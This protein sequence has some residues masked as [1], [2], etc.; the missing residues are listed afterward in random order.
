EFTALVDSVRSELSVRH[1]LARQA[2]D[3]GG[4]LVYDDVVS[5][6]AELASDTWSTPTKWPSSCTPQ[7]RRAGPRAPCSPTATCSGTTS[8][9]RWPSTRSRTTS[10]SC[11]P[12]SSTSGGST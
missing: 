5:S 2:S 1:F 4:W 3:G 12:L 6:A 9:P 11:A 8:T 7:V 10:P